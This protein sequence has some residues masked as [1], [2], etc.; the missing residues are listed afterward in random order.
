MKEFWRLP[1]ILM[2]TIGIAAAA[3]SFVNSKTKPFIERHKTETLQAVLLEALPAA[4]NGKLVPVYDQNGNI[5]YYKG[6]AGTDTTQACGYIFSAAGFGY[7]STIVALV[8]V[9]SKGV[10]QGIQILE[11]TETPGLGTR[12][13]EIKYGESKPWFLAQFADLSGEHLSLVKD[14]GANNSITGAT[15]SSRA[16]TESVRQGLGQLAKKVGGFPKKTKPVI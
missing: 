9:D 4:K 12:I 6:F 16:V 13:Q 3:L 2:L 10:I 8:G 11:Q 7:A 14:G 1:V 15:I 5:D